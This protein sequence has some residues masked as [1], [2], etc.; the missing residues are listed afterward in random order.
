M[1]LLLLLRSSTVIKVHTGLVL[2]NWRGRVV[3]PTVVVCAEFRGLVLAGVR[4]ELA[5]HGR[6]IRF[7]TLLPDVVAVALLVLLRR[8]RVAR[9]G[10]HVLAVSTKVLLLHTRACDIDDLLPRSVV[11]DSNVLTAQQLLV[12]VGEGIASGGL[13]RRNRIVGPQIGRKVGLINF[14]DVA[15]VAVVDVISRVLRVHSRHT[16]SFIRQS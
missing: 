10:W 6:G 3:R 14:R 2:R 11:A 5:G 9:R 4:L 15:T 13:R 1:L 16:N 7:S 8:A 12:D